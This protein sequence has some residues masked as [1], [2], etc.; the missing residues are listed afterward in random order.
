MIKLSPILDLDGQPMRRE[1]L[2]REIAA[3]AL[4]GVRTIW[5]DSVASGLTPERLADLLNRAAEGDPR[6]Y[7]VLA[8]EMEEREAHYGS[9]LG[10]RKRALSALVPAVEAA[11]DDPRDV[12]LADEV[13]DLARDPQFPDML[14]DLLDA[15]GKGYS[16]AEIIWNT[17]RT[18]WKPERY[19]HRDPRWFSFDRESGRRLL[20]LDDQ[21]PMGMPLAPYRF[22][23]HVPRLKSGLPIRGGLARL[24]A[25]SFMFKGYAVKDWM[26]FIEVFGLPLRIGKYGQ[27]ASEDDIDTLVRAVTNIGTDAAAV[28]PESMAIEFKDTAAGKGGHEVF[29]AMAEWIDEQVSKAVLGQTMTADNGS[30]QSQAEVHNEVRHDILRSDARQL[31]MTL[32]RD[33]VRPY[34]DLNHGPQERYP[35]LT[36]P[37]LEPED[38]KALVDALAKLVPLGFRVEQSVIRD[39]LN[40]PDPA[41][42]ADVLVPPTAPPA[43]APEAPGKAQNRE[44]VRDDRADPLDD[45]ERTGLEDWE[46]QLAPVVDPVRALI[47]SAASYEEAIAGL[48]DLAM[49]SDQL[50]K[51]LT[52]AMFLSRAAGDQVD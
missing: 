42:D 1:D 21:A 10:T 44:E 48:A 52:R 38:I 29:K 20:L 32:N 22:I 36:L 8:E 2:S 16:V 35:L 46:E 7:L 13:R 25:W 11:S 6:D 34:I 12:A 28:I 45:I 50:V 33:L 3:P 18:P 23:T 19:E 17:R 40:L 47:S 37:V 41:A 27:S 30:S 39:K 9:V 31:A 24:V 4:A 15:L 49:D 14:D 26:A 51:A 5:T 43:A